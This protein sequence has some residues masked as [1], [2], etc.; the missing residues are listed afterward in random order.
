MTSDVNVSDP[1]KVEAKNKNFAAGTDAGYCDS[2]AQGFFLVRLAQGHPALLSTKPPPALPFSIPKHGEILTA[3]PQSTSTV[4]VC[5]PALLTQQGFTSPCRAALPFSPSRREGGSKAKL[6]SVPMDTDGHQPWTARD[7]LISA[8]YSCHSAPSSAELLRKSP[9]GQ[10]QSW[11][12]E[13]AQWSGARAPFLQSCSAGE[14]TYLK[15]EVQLKCAWHKDS[16]ATQGTVPC[17]GLSS[18]I[19]KQVWPGTLP[20]LRH[21]RPLLQFSG[22]CHRQT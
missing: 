8:P 20:F 3:T 11:G 5:I 9:D 1:A 10:T 18:I 14:Y 21:R 7:N 19:L 22:G 13:C 2:S 4:P 17:T 15:L 6:I 16:K 12:D